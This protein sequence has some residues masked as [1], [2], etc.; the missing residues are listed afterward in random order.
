ME[1]LRRRRPPSD[2]PAH[3]AAPT[4][5]EAAGTRPAS[6]AASGVTTPGTP[7][8]EPPRL[9]EAP[10]EILLTRTSIEQRARDHLAAVVG[11]LSAAGIEHWHVPSPLRPS[12]TRLGTFAPP[13]EVLAAVAG[14][15]TQW[16]IEA[17]DAD[18]RDWAQPDPAQL[19]VGPA[20]LRLHTTV[21]DPGRNRRIAV[22]SAVEVET[23]ARADGQLVAALP[24]VRGTTIPADDPRT[25]PADVR[26]QQ[27]WTWASLAVRE[28]TA[29]SDPVDA[30]VTWVN[31]D[32]PGYWAARSPWLADLAG[33][34]EDPLARAEARTRSFDELRFALRSLDM[35]APWLRR[36]WLLTDMQRPEWIDTG[37]ITVVDHQEVLGGHVALPTF[38]SHA[39]ESGMHRIEGLAEHFIYVNDDTMLGT[40]A[41][42]TDFFTPAGHPVFQP[43]GEFLPAGPVGPDEAAPGIAGRTVRGLLEDEFGLTV[44][45]KLRHTPHPLTRSLMTDVAQRYPQHWA[46]TAA[47]RFRSPGDIPPVSLALW[48]ALMAGRAATSHPTYTYVE[49]SAVAG[50]EELEQLA[51]QLRRSAFFCVNLRQDP[52]MP[53]PELTAATTALLESLFPFTSRFER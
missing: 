40:R 53:W 14:L 25:A 34:R 39:I 29:M 31:S 30:V 38:N 15:G 27:L 50:P 4:R 43:S 17:W 16:T 35:Y 44:T 37:T 6:D 18:S 3:P 1:F 51:G 2:P 45:H 32:D 19:V 12:R 7:A 23:W 24:H 5:P 9:D 41:Q 20:A 11:A 13:A 8:P 48:Y 46:T 21:W 52:V 10:V 49:L 22:I 42:P 36:V 26:G 47:N 33:V 28:P